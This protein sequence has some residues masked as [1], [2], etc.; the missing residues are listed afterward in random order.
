MTAATSQRDPH[1]PRPPQPVHQPRGE[2]RGDAAARPRPARPPPRCRP[3]RRA[4]A[5]MPVNACRNS[6][7]ISSVDTPNASRCAASARNDAATVGVRAVARAPS[8]RPWATATSV[9]SGASVRSGPSS[10]RREA[11]GEH[12]G[13]HRPH[14]GDGGGEGRTR[15]RRAPS[16]ARGP[17]AVAAPSAAIP[18]P[19]VAAS[20]VGLHEVASRDDVR[21]RRRQP[22]QHEPAHARRRPARRGRAARRPRPAYTITATT[23]SA[24]RAAVGDEQHPA[25]VPAVQQGAGERARPASTA[26]GARRARRRRPAGRPARSGL[27]STAPPSAAW[28]MPSPHCAAKRTASS[29]R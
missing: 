2:Q 8:T 26:G 18:A 3:A 20:D 9:R 15:R 7:S 27:N 19:A 29:R 11:R 4:A 22:G 21:Q 5:P 14:R 17:I 10:R 6:S 28:N 16:S 12:R 24:P 13:Q 25:A 23:T 1:R